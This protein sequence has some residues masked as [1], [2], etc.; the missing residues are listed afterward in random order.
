[1][2]SFRKL[3]IAEPIIKAIANEKFEIPSEIQEKAIPAA[4]SGKD[5]IAGSATG[6]GKT[7]VFGADIIQNTEKEGKLRALVLTPTRELADQITKA[8]YRFSKYK[9]LKIVPIYGGVSINPQIEQLRNADVV[10][11]TPGRLM[12][13][14]K[15]NT[16]N[17]RGIKILVIDEADRMFDMGF[18]RDVEMIIRECPRDRQT[19]LFSATITK[20]VNH[21]AA[22]YM[23]NPLEIA[24][25]SFVDPKKLIQ[26]YY[27]IDNRNKF[28]LLVHL[29]KHEKSGLVMV[30]CNT[31]GSVNFVVGNLQSVGIPAQAMHGG[32]AQGKRSSVLE[33]FHAQTVTILVCTD[34]AA[35]GL[36]IPGVSH[37]YNYDIPADSKLYI[38]RVGRTARAGADGIAV[39]LVS[40]EQHQNFAGVIKDNDF[41]IKKVITPEFERVNIEWKERPR[42]SGG[43]R[44]GFGHRSGFGGRPGFGRSRS[45]FRGRKKKFAGPRYR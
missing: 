30:F 6:S 14:M 35:R 28:S 5:I 39:N 19:L 16:M 15:R 38:H 7:L 29:L 36:D 33:S 27:D 1:M 3:G 43:G 4:L 26:V 24:A 21:L 8:L 20:E 13:H 45:G 37:I 25:A 42:F 34:V 22:K 11:A 31:R 32:F 18:I 44:P 9:H 41:D 17:L 12:D 23:R 2:E 40:R 10:V